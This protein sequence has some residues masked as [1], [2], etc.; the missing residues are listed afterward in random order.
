M[1][2]RKMPLVTDEIYHVFNRGINRQPTFNSKREYERAMLALSF[3]QVAKPPIRLSKFLV[4]N[5]DVQESLLKSMAEL[6][7]L[8]DVISFCLMPNHF[9]FLLKQK[10]DKGI[11]NFLGNFQ[12]S[13]TRYFNTKNKR[14]G[15]IFL[16]QFKAVRIV[17]DEQLI[18]VSR[19]IHLN[20]YTGFVV[21]TLSELENYEWSSLKDYLKADFT[22]INP[23]LV[24][25]LFK[26][27]NSYKQFVFDQADY[28]RELKLIEHLTLE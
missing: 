21:K 3:Y 22:S 8:V 19:Y 20:P 26:D 6:S 23:E 28:Q 2:T 7:K 27:S 12:N 1:P 9:H 13:Y 11:S 10:Q 24:L 25:G 14:D 4:Q 15:S 17:T 18:H 16:T 5:P